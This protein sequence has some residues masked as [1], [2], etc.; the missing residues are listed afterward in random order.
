MKEIKL[1]IP[2]EWS[3][4]TIQKYQRYVEIQEGKGT[5]QN[6]AI[7][8]I[9]LFCNVKKSIIRKM[10]YV[11]MIEIIGIIKK[12]IDTEPDKTKFRKQ[13][14]FG[15]DEYGFIPNLSKLTTGEYIDLEEYCKEPI[16]NLHIIMSILYRKIAFR[17]FGRYSI[18]SY[19]PDEFKEDLF[20]K[21]PMDIALGSL[22]FFLTLGEQLANSS[23]SYLLAQEKKLQKA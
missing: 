9:S 20:K 16:K 8:V 10:S 6:K 17:R 4:I 19:D 13:F 22:G 11:D 3:D 15:K 1:S 12:L 23:H 14:T 5:D 21:C 2:S 18:E 7:R